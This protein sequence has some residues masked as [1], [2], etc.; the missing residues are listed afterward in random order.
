MER[1]LSEMSVQTVPAAQK[2]TT[3]ASCN[4]AGACAAVAA[5][6]ATY[7]SSRT[8]GSQ[9]DPERQRQKED[10]EHPEDVG[11][12]GAPHGSRTFDSP[13]SLADRKIR[14]P[15]DSL[16]VRGMSQVQRQQTEHFIALQ[17]L[18][19]TK[20]RALGDLCRRIW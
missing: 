6:P 13:D 7:P 4:V 1:K 14:P 18:S 5:A 15:R 10:S 19:F 17:Y 12:A 16:P 2:A 11:A 20:N 9:K 3:S 8:S